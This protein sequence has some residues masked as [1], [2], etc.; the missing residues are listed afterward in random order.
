MVRRV[1]AVAV[2][3]ASG[4]LAC[5]LATSLD[6]LSETP[7]SPLPDGFAT[8]TTEGG[9][10]T[11]LQDA[12]SA[13]EAG[14]G[15]SAP[16]DAGA[17]CATVGPD[18]A[19]C[20]DY[21]E[22]D[23]TLAYEDGVI[24]HVGPPE[25]CKGCSASDDAGGRESASAFLVQLPA[26]DGG[27]VVSDYFDHPAVFPA[28]A[29]TL[30]FDMQIL[31]LMQAKE[32]DFVALH[33]QTSSSQ[34]LDSYFLLQSGAGSLSLATASSFKDTPVPIPADGQWHRYALSLSV[35]PATA[36][37]SVD[38]GPAIPVSLSSVALTIATTSFDLGPTAYPPY[39]PIRIAFDN[40]VL[41]TR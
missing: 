18:A 9:N 12:A 5:S 2:A 11:L 8:P 27:A 16:A 23:P 37:L 32:V 3:I 24:T 39:G 6:G 22:A 17:S 20:A 30:Q 28:R 41:T 19:F 33:L 14:G 40:V 13:A 1:L 38:H 15:D 34:S 36:S 25:V 7:P 26:S 10:T 29:A 21:E 31:E 35:S 4:M